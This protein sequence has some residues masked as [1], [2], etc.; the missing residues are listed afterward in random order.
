MGHGGVDQSPRLHQGWGGTAPGQEM[1]NPS[2]G[3][4]LSLI[5]WDCVALARPN[6]GLKPEFY[7]LCMIPKWQGKDYNYKWSCSAP[8]TGLKQ[9]G[10]S[11]KEPPR[12]R[13]RDSRSQSRSD[14]F[15]TYHTE[16]G[17]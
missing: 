14:C 17:P 16:R 2:P 8:G 1:A 6:V 3:S 11:G 9:T 10:F 13:S 12:P 15:F 4:L 5:P 7:T